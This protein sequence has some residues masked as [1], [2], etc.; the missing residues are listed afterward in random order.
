[1]KKIIFSLFL[2]MSISTIANAT[3]FEKNEIVPEFHQVLISK[4]RHIDLNGDLKKEFVFFGDRESWAVQYDKTKS[5]AA[6]GGLIALSFFVGG[7]SAQAWNEMLNNNQY[8]LMYDVENTKKEK[9]RIIAMFSANDFDDK[10][11]IKNYLDEK[12]QK[13]IK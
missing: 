6:K 2:I 8:I 12:I 10:D 7:M 9:T 11:V 3:F 5:V 4:T 13:E 1:M